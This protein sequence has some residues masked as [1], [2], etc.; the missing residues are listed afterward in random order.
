M[1]TYYVIRGTRLGKMEDGNYYLFENGK[2]IPDTKNT[3][4]DYLMGFDP[5]EPAGSPYGI[6]S[7]SIIDQIEEIP[8]KEAIKMINRLML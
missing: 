3:I 8:Q 5:C 1:T 4:Q 2:W 6:G 7:M